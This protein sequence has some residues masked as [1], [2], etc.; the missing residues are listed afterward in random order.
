MPPKNHPGFS[1]G[2]TVKARDLQ[3]V[4]RPADEELLEHCRSGRPAYILHS[5]QMGKSSLIARTAEQLK[6]ESRHAIIIDLSQFPL[7][8][9]EKEWFYKILLLLDDQLDLSTDASVWWDTHD[10]IPPHERLTQFIHEVVLPETTNP[11]VFFIDEIEQ[12]LTIPFRAHLF[13]WLATL[14]ESRATHP[15]LNRITFV[16]CGVATPLQLIPD[17]NPGLFQWSHQVVLS[18]FTL[19]EA[20]PLSEGLSLPAET[21]VETFQWVYRWTQGHPYLTQ[22]VCQVLEEQHRS[23]WSER[24]IDECIRHFLVS[25]QGLQDRNLQLVRNTLTTLGTNSVS[26]LRPFLDLLEGRQE[27]LKTDTAIFDQ[28]QLAGVLREDE[29]KIGLGNKLYQELFTPS[30][31]RR[32]LPIKPPS[33][34]RA[35]LIAASALLLGLGF[36]LGLTLAPP[37]QRAAPTA[38]STLLS[39]NMP[40]SSEDTGIVSKQPEQ[41]TRSKPGQAAPQERTRERKSLLTQQQPIPPTEAKRFMKN[42]VLLETQ[43]ASVQAEFVHTQQLLQNTEH[44]AQ[45]QQKRAQTELAQFQ[46]DRSQLQDQVKASQEKSQAYLKKITEL[47]GIISRQNTAI[48]EAIAGKNLLAAQLQTINEQMNTIATDLATT[49]QN[50]ANQQVRPRDIHTSSSEKTRRGEN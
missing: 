17:G 25:P 18:D 6:A 3:Y 44:T 9:R 4:Q 5:P 47:E 20:L 46:E 12:T 22:L 49:Q 21:A 39:E 38:A 1:S 40:S 19:Q 29:G 24:E 7:P 34:H 50:F 31:V 13:D 27:T 26:L 32:H 15:P 28:L 36:L 45:E 48:H 30:W 41:L 14:Y 11:L 37:D 33:P 35:S 42:P 16:V 10:S 43:L 2:R 8:P 23:T